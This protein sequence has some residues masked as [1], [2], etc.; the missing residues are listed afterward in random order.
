M[1]LPLSNKEVSTHPGKNSVVDPVDKKAQA[2]DV[3]RKL[4]FYGVIQAFR[5]GRLPSNQQIDETLNY[6]LNHSPVDET[7][8]S[9]EGKNLVQDVRDII[10]TAGLMVKQKNADELFQNFIFH[11]QAVD[12]N[13]LKDH[14]T[15]HVEGSKTLDTDKAKQDGDQAVQHLRTL[16]TLVLTNS[17]VRKL[18]SDFS[19]I[20]R[21]LL[22]IGASKAASKIAPPEHEMRKVDEAA[23]SDQFITEGGRQVGPNET[24]VLA[25]GVRV[26]GVTEG[27]LRMDPKHDTQPILHTQDGD[28]IPLGDKAKEGYAQYHQVRQQG[29]GAATGQAPNIDEEQRER[30]QGLA[31]QA[32]E[33]AKEEALEYKRADEEGD[34]ETKEAK[35]QGVRERLRGMK[36]SVIDTFHERVPEEH[37][38]K[39]NEQLESSKRFFTEEYFPEERRDQFIFR[40]KKVVIEC[41]KHNDY[42]QSMTWLLD[43]G[44]IDGLALNELSNVAPCKVPIEVPAVHF[45]ELLPREE[46]VHHFGCGAAE[47]VGFG[48]RDIAAAHGRSEVSI[49]VGRCMKGRRR[50][51]G[52]PQQSRHQPPGR[53]QRRWR[54]QQ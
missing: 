18:L 7:K 1:S 45:R 37:R 51:Q 11:T 50:T 6:V 9:P 21:D 49:H 30:A 23:P 27:T 40:L 26:P 28:H 2:A 14:A 38:N 36:D 32:K 20:G 35:K 4:K 24:P 3:E 44:H 19:L 29:L 15:N 47:E 25:E 22:A 34:E 16:L 33:R 5:D 39:A 17:E 12:T 43:F 41:Q 53:A 31:A 8:L 48:G 54:G 52:P 46:V 42:Q 13:S 10:K